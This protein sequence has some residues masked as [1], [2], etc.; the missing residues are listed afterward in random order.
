MNDS[1]ALDASATWTSE[2]VSSD[3]LVALDDYSWIQDP[4]R[5]HVT[6]IHIRRYCPPGVSEIIASGGQCFIGAIDDSTVLKY[7]QIP[8]ELEESVHIESQLLEVLGNP[9][10]PHIIA[11]KGMTEH[12]L[13]LQ[14]ASGCLND[15]IT[16]QTSIPFER[17]LL[18]CKQAAQAVSYI[19]G[20]NVIHCDISLRN[21]LLDKNLDLLLAD[22]QGV[23]KSADGETL[24]DGHAREHSKAYMPRVGD[25]ACVKTDLFA[26]GTA[27]YEIM[28][29]HEVFPE[30]NTWEEGVDEEILS[31][32]EN[33]LF[34]TDKHACYRVTEKRWK[35]QYDSADD[36]LSDLSVI[37]VSDG[38]YSQTGGQS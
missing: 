1:K 31:R 14:R 13:I 23:L 5:P 12:G 34:P 22:F 18:W 30:L 15:Y 26:L 33:G 4:A 36:V 37:Q 27:I 21:T 35:Q 38:A 10:H 11:S 25:D 32:F 6:I 19:H 28:T 8:E 17:R 9:G 2:I 20:K 24:L 29:G 16:S 3:I 7:P